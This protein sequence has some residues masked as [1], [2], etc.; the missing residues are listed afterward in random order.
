MILDCLL[1]GSLI[2]SCGKLTCILVQKTILAESAGIH[3]QS[4]SVQWDTVLPCFTFTY[5]E[6]CHWLRNLT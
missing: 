1:F 5:L 3:L 6:Y 4:T 2:T